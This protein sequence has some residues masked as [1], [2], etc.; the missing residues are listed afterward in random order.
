MSTILHDKDMGFLN[1]LYENAPS[2]DT[3][4]ARGEEILKHYHSYMENNFSNYTATNFNELSE[5]FGPHKWPAMVENVGMNQRVFEFSM[6]EAKDLMEKLA[7]QSQGKMPQDW[8]I[9]HKAVSNAAKNP[10]FWEALKFTAWES[11]AQILEETANVGKGVI[12]TLRLSPYLIP[13]LA[14]MGGGLAVWYLTRKL[15]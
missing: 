3:D 8:M 15:K 2:P 4:F 12:N 11:S 7:D 6:Q 13:A 9:F 5:V 1:F 10:S 14:V